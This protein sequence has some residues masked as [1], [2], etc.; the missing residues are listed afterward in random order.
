[1][2]FR[3]VNFFDRDILEK[4]YEEMSE[5]FSRVGVTSFAGCGNYDWM[6]EDAYAIP[7]RMTGS[8]R[9]GQ[10]FFECTFVETADRAEPALEELIRLSKIY[11]NDKFRVN[12]YK[13]VSYTHLDVY[14]RQQQIRAIMRAAILS[15]NSIAESPVT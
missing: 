3:K 8:G 14:K 9:L 2:I 15:E 12:T 1:M 4:S 11:D 6:G 7:A 5:E 13:A 10:R